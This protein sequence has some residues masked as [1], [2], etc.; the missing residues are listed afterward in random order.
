MPIR[1]C[2]KFS[3][4]R[5]TLWLKK[6]IT[7]VTS[8]IFQNTVKSC[9]AISVPQTSQNQ[10]LTVF[11][12]LYFAPQNRFCTVCMKSLFFSIQ[13][14]S[15]GKRETAKKL[16]LL[17]AS[18]QLVTKEKTIICLLWSHEIHIRRSRKAFWISLKSEKMRIQKSNYNQ[19]LTWYLWEFSRRDAATNML[20]DKL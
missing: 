18:R 14:L 12:Q 5:I 16:K 15:N 4:S 20:F 2:E 1:A 10:H 8:D 19:N 6:F 9:D 17:V 11:V 7:F 3:K 13:K